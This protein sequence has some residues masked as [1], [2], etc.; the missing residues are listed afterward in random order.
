MSFHA[1]GETVECPFLFWNIRGSA[2]GTYSVSRTEVAPTPGSYRTPVQVGHADVTATAWYS[3]PGG[4]GGAALEFDG[5][6]EDDDAFFDPTPIES[7]VPASAWGRAEEDVFVRTAGQPTRTTLFEARPDELSQQFQRFL[8]MAGGTAS[9]RTLDAAAEAGGLVIA[10][11]RRPPAPRF[12]PPKVVMVPEGGP[13]SFGV[14]LGVTGFVY[15]PGGIPMPVDPVPFLWHAISSGP[16]NRVGAPDATIR[17]RQL[18]AT[19]DFV[20]GL[21]PAD[22]AGKVVPLM[23][24]AALRQLQASMPGPIH[25]ARPEDGIPGT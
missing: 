19:S 20:K 12:E 25:A 22:L 24:E 9:G 23:M 3:L 1:R 13:V 6:S 18:L 5:F 10:S 14:M 15:G 8:I 7:V 17:V 16:P 4:G 21:L 11:Y 2:R